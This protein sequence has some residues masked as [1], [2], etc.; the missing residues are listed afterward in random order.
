VTFEDEESTVNLELYDAVLELGE[1]G[2][3]DYK[4]I[5]NL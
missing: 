3:W 4:S 2:T 1:D 5:K